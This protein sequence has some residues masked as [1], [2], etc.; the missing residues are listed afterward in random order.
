[1][2]NQY[3]IADQNYFLFTN[4]AWA[5]NT[6]PANF[7]YSDDLYFTSNITDNRVLDI[8]TGENLKSKSMYFA[9]SYAPYFGWQI[10][11]TATG[12]IN[13]GLIKV[14]NSAVRINC[15]VGADLTGIL[16]I[17]TTN[18]TPLTL[19][20]ISN[21]QG[22]TF[23]ESGSLIITDQ[24]ALGIV[25][26]TLR[27]NNLSLKDGTSLT[28]PATTAETVAFSTRGV[29]TWYPGRGI[30][31][32]GTGSIITSYTNNHAFDIQTQVTG[33]GKIVFSKPGSYFNYV[34]LTGSTSSLKNSG[35]IT[36]QHGQ[37]GIIYA[38][39]SATLGDGPIEF[40]RNTTSNTCLE[41]IYYNHDPLSLNNVIKND[42]L[43]K[44]YT[45]NFGTVS[46][47]Y[48]S[49][50]RGTATANSSYTH[51][52]KISTGGY[53]S[54]THPRVYL[55]Y[56]DH[57][58][59]S[60][61][62]KTS[63]IFSG[64]NSELYSSK[65][66][67]GYTYNTNHTFNG[68]KSIPHASSTLVGYYNQTYHTEK[69]SMSW[70][71]SGSMTVGCNLDTSTG[72]IGAK[73]NV[74]K[75]KVVTHTGTHAISGSLTR[76]TTTIPAWQATSFVG[77]GE[78]IERGKISGPGSLVLEPTSK[79]TLD[80][81]PNTFAGVV[82]SSF[83]TLKIGALGGDESLGAIPAVST[84]KLF[85]QNST[86]VSSAT[87]AFAETR[88]ISLTGAIIFD[89]EKDK[90]IKIPAKISGNADITLIGGGTLI[91]SG[92]N[93]ITGSININTGSLEFMRNVS[94]PQGT[95]TLNP[96]GSIIFPSGT[97]TSTS[98]GV[99]LVFN[100]GNVAFL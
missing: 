54:T 19:A 92:G 94:M 99:S 10:G 81:S 86:L 1:M 55:G 31:V 82:S 29:T 87:F 12:T 17:D 40:L 60:P 89:I 50:I 3:W 76:A 63:F 66:Y 85:L 51:T 27:A 62:Y 48:I 77:E 37:N 70:I 28:L 74:E 34:Y 2:A 93:N 33:S 75:N 58:T 78:W 9:D 36:V 18:S 88:E 13:T 41:I 6:S 15:A 42:I 23:I 14:R 84:Q 39:S 24:R 11:S 90:V 100:G 25:P 67:L 97:F 7:T 22:Y 71:F 47:R 20:S 43:F 61:Y 49:D 26:G 59:A 53:I 8:F 80:Y 98:P 46:S 45:L 38:S 52:G 44:G 96:S 91:L 30:T 21:T 35:G 57:A 69:D 95:I 5:S 56:V 64:D 4:Y 65:L 72:T 68:Q 83:A 32:S 73:I 79:L 16:K